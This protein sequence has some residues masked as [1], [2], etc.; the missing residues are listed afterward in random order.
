VCA[1]LVKPKVFGV[2]FSIICEGASSKRALIQ[3]DFAT[4]DQRFPPKEL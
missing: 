4:E 2:T 1:S 3:T